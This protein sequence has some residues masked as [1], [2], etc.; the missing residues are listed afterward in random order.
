MS[1]PYGGIR[2]TLIWCWNGLPS[3]STVGITGLTRSGCTSAVADLVG[4]VGDDLHPDP[5]PGDARQH[6]AVQSEVEDLL[7]VARD[8]WSA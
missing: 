2:L 3:S 7:D 4:D 1:R 6:E 5:E 8:R